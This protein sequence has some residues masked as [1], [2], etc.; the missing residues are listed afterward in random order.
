VV[1]VLS[2]VVFY[3]AAIPVSVIVCLL[4]PIFSAGIIL[5]SPLGFIYR[6]FIQQKHDDSAPLLP[7]HRQHA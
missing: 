4:V 6:Y 7:H 2:R 5:M 1:R 3:L